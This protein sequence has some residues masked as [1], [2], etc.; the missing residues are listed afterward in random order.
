MRRRFA[1]YARAVRDV[2]RE[3]AAQQGQ[4]IE[5]DFPVTPTA[6][7]GYGRPPHPELAVMIAGGRDRYAAHL[8]AIAALTDELVAIPFEADGREPRWVNGYFQGLDAASLYMFLVGRRPA[9]YLEVGAG[10]STRFA[11]R[12]I[13]RNGLATRIVSIDPAPRADLA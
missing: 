7:W 5:L 1:S 4:T 10:H 12:A 11:R 2:R 6:R 8:D 3:D 13:E 9:T